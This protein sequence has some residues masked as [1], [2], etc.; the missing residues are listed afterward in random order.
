MRY[1]YV[2]LDPTAHFTSCRLI[3][4][5]AQHFVQCHRPNVALARRAHSLS[6]IV[7]A[8]PDRRSRTGVHFYNSDRG[9]Q[10]N[11]GQRAVKVS[12]TQ[13]AERTCLNKPT[14]SPCSMLQ[15]GGSTPILDK[16][17]DIKFTCVA[18][19]AEALFTRVPQRSTVPDGLDDV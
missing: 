11:Q 9:D 4:P 12:S 19:A 1:F 5:W 13:L 8:G 7:G 6:S 16:V 18:L 17:F 10:R 2:C 3:I 15:A 14:N